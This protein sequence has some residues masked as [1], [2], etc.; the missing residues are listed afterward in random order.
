MPHAT[1]RHGVARQVL[2]TWR[3]PRCG[4]QRHVTY[5][6]P[7]TGEP[8]RD[9]GDLPEC[10]DLPFAVLDAIASWLDERARDGEGDVREPDD[11]A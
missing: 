7:V 8:E 6:W 11:E 1:R 3:C 2:L 5:T 9:Y 10:C 4:K